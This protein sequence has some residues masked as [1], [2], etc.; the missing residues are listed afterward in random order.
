MGPSRKPGAGNVDRRE[1]SPSSRWK[2]KSS[3][4]QT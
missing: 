4:K 3:K 2:N 1:I